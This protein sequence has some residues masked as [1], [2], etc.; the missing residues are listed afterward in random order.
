L[1]I[2]TG[3]VTQGPVSEVYKL[4]KWAPFFKHKEETY[5]PQT[6]ETFSELLKTVGFHDIDVKRERVEHLFKDEKDLFNMVFSWVPHS[7]GLPDDKARKFTQDIVDRVCA[8]R[9]DGQ[10]IFETALLDA[11]V[12]K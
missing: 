6:A 10:I 3:A 1:F 9:D 7:T 5:F 4:K 8:A 2:K 12:V 11:R